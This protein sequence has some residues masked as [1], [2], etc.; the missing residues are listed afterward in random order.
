MKSKNENNQ[1]IVLSAREEEEE[2]EKVG[3]TNRR[4][5]RKKAQTVAWFDKGVRTE[6]RRTQFPRRP[7]KR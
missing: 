2:E 5:D 6:E 1:S 7:F 3:G 4:T